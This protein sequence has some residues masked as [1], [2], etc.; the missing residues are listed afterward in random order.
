M[1]FL[2]S[3]ICFLVEELIRM[4]HTCLR[5]IGTSSSPHRTTQKP[6]DNSLKECFD[7]KNNLGTVFSHRLRACYESRQSSHGYLQMHSNGDG[8]PAVHRD[9]QSSAFRNACFIFRQVISH[10]ALTAPDE[11][12]QHH[13]MPGPTSPRQ[14]NYATFHKFRLTVGVNHN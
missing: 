1:H 10:I 14:S 5:T 6:E 12:A 2:G 4:D 8:S 9:L 3:N 13:S 7:Q 11:S